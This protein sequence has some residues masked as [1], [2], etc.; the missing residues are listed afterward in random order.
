M[1]RQPGNTELR[2]VL[3]AEGA[4]RLMDREL[5]A[6]F[7]EGD[8]GVF[9]VIVKRH[10]A[11]VLGV[12]RCVLPIVQDAEYA[13]QATFLVLAQ[14][15]KTER[16]QTS[17]ANWLY[18]TARR[19]ALTATRSASRMKRPSH[20]AQAPA[21]STLDEMTVIEGVTKTPSCPEIDQKK[22][23]ISQA[24]HGHSVPRGVMSYEQKM[25]K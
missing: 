20:R 5:L 24:R 18:I 13:C 16:W 15:A 3:S 21:I 4:K 2:A 6:Q 9:A 22:C 11:M 1:A 7:C 25:N 19:I 10:T 23:S 12:C 17:I 14:K 8:Q